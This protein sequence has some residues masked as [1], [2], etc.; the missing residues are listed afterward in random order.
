MTSR[1]RITQQAAAWAAALALAASAGCS[2]R[3][4]PA[5]PDAPPEVVHHRGDRF[6][7]RYVEFETL[8][9]RAFW[10]WKFEQ[11]RD[12]LPPPSPPAPR[13]AADHAFLDA[14]AAAGAAMQT[15]VT[16]IGHATALV[17]MGG[18]AI[19]TDP[20]FSERA[21]PV[22]FAGPKRAQPPGLALD[23]LPRVDAVVVSHN[24]YDHCD[25]PSLVALAK[26]RGGSPLFVVP[27]G[28]R[29]LLVEAGIDRVVEL[30]WW[31]ST[32][33]EGASGP[34]EIVLVPVQHWSGR[35]LDDRMRTLWGG[36]AVF[37]PGGSFYFA[38][39]TG[40][41]PDF[42]DARARFAPRLVDGGFDLALLPIGAYEPR[43]FMKLSHMNPTEAVQAS[44]D[45]GAKLTV[46][47]HWGTFPLTDEALDQP[48]KDLDA[49]RVARGLRDG[50][51]VVLPIGETL[52]LLD[53]RGEATVAGAA[54]PP[55]PV[56]RSEPGDGQVAPPVR[57][58]RGS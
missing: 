21:S 48:P 32:K 20:I 29:A 54:G 37:A 14:N 42:A 10:R 2:T 23:Q 18:V 31:Q 5:S 55:P 8:G 9:T 28:L 27:L 24:H 41:S 34:V 47:I 58:A 51:F 56:P 19:L 22:S 46:G 53:R 45:L 26:Q 57:A 6:Q 40:Y 35:R 13:V 12:G 7:N 1:R 3:P 25:L 11:W 30:D 39:D 16:W 17:Q 49:A 50:S 43:W 15:S 52:G 33:V 4:P 44:I 38:G 36:Y